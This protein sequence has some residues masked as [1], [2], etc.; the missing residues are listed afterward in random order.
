MTL[1]VETTGTTGKTI[2]DELIDLTDGDRSADSTASSEPE[3]RRRLLAAGRFLVAVTGALVIFGAFMV[4]KGANPLDAYS[5]M[6][7]STLGDSTSLGEILIRA[8]PII[9]AALAVAVPARAGCRSRRSR[10]FLGPGGGRAE[11]RGPAV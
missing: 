7:T 3:W 6:V 4:A 1:E 8:A 2:D 10:A 5:D 11:K 9:L